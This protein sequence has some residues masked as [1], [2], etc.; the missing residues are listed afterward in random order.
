[1]AAK[2]QG[3]TRPTRGTET[4]ST[5]WP[6]LNMTA[7]NNR[8][9]RRAFRTL[10]SGLRPLLESERLSHPVRR[11]LGDLATRS[12]VAPATLVHH[13][14]VAGVPGR[15]ARPGGAD[16]EAVILYLHGGGYTSGSSA[17]FIGFVSHLAQR[18][19]AQ[20]FVPDYRL[21][22]ENPYP[23]AVDDA[24]TAYR[25][26]LRL[27]Y[28]PSRVAVAGESAGAGLALALALRLRDGGVPL[29]TVLA[30][31]CPWLD[32][33]ADLAGTREF[34]RDPLA[35]PKLGFACAQAY[36]G[37]QDPRDVGISP[38]HGDLSGLPPMLIQSARED[39]F[40][41]DAH[42]LAQ[43]A[44]DAGVQVEHQCWSGVWHGFQLQ[45]AV[46][47]DADR[48]VSELAR[49]LKIYLRPAPKLPVADPVPDLREILH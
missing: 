22:P 13:G 30:L 24:E 26:L 15:W 1:M 18:S 21:A 28:A 7:S 8:L 40:G 6:K 34:R 11:R 9:R 46:L 36:S 31:E 3:S 43:R 16:S 2:S 12:P 23:A 29:P 10:L 47:T 49:A 44:R 32:L 19:A 17:G 5:P 45:R 37:G 33:A 35:S 20:A 39:L 48:A 25:G 4:A 42:L 27:G 41:P 38:V 14:A